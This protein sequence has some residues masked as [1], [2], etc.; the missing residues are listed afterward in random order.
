MELKGKLLDV[1]NLKVSFYTY[2]GVVQALNGVDLWMDSGERLGV[3]G[4]TG[5]GKSV[6]SLAVMRLIEQPGEIQ[7]GKV[8]FNGTNLVE[9]TE[10]KM[11]RV[12]GAEMS[13]IFQEPRSSLN[14]VM[15]VGYQI[16]ESIAKSKKLKIK[17]TYPEVKEILRLVGLDPERVMNSYPHELSGGMSQRVMI[18]MGLA[19]HPKLLIA[20]EPTSAL[21]VTIQAQILELLDELARK[22]GNAVMLITHDMGVVAEFCD[23]VLVMY[24]GNSVEYASTARLFEKPLHPYTGGLLQAVPRVGRTDELK[25]IK[26]TVPDLVNPPSGCRFHPRCPHSMDICKV[27]RPPFV[28][29]EPDHY[30][31]CYLFEGKS[32]VREDA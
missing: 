26:G 2:R 12:R 20:D 3:V 22:M 11:N 16:G 19:S 25:A 4:E 32:E 28:E 23:K 21:D 5:C 30:V 1:S 24:A 14:P 9:L 6:T 31:A 15:K 27:E 17:H 10:E 7:E 29:I 18:G 13:M 8:I